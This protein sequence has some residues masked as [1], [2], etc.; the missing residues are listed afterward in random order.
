MASVQSPLSPHLP[1]MNSL[2]GAAPAAGVAAGVAASATF[3]A[4]ALLLAAASA[5]LSAGAASTALASASA[6]L[7]A[8]FS[9]VS[10]PPPQAVKASA[11]PAA[12]MMRSFIDCSPFRFR[13][14]DI[15][16]ETSVQRVL[17]PFVGNDGALRRPDSPP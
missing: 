10:E 6:V 8:V 4:S 17:S 5:A 12:R 16:D 1:T 9:V 3:V 7:A 15:A 13:N 14:E 2:V 11:A